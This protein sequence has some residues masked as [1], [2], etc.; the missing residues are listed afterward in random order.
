MRK[1]AKR[2][3]VKMIEMRVRKQNQVNRREMFDLQPRAFQTLQK[4]QPVGEIR[5]NE[6]VQIMELNQEGRMA[7]P[8]QRDLPRAQFGEHRPLVLSL[9]AHEQ[10]LPH[11]LIKKGARIKRLGGRQL[12]ERTRQTLTR[13]AWTMPMAVSGF[14]RACLTTANLYNRHE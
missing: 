14:H 3:F 10:D 2:W 8:G 7:D 4:E 6:N 12:L 13:P 9:A 11:H 1:A 5:V